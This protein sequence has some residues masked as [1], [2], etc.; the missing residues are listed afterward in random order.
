MA[1]KPD[2]RIGRLSLLGLL[3]FIIGGVFLF[4]PDLV[5]PFKP[6]PIFH[7]VVYVPKEVIGGRINEKIISLKKD[8]YSNKQ[9]KGEMEVTQAVIKKEPKKKDTLKV[10]I[11]NLQNE[12]T[13][14]E[15]DI[16]RLK[17]IKASYE[18]TS[19]ADTMSFDTLNKVLHFK[20][21]PD[22]L[23]KWDAAYCENETDT[24][25]EVEFILK[26][27]D[28][29]FSIEGKARL[30][31]RMPRSDIEFMTKYPNAGLWLLML[32]VFCSFLF[33]AASTSFYLRRQ[34][35]DLFTVKE[36]E[37]LSIWNY[38]III[39][40]T[41]LG[42]FAIWGIGRLSFND[43]DVVR[44]IFFLRNISTSLLWIQGV[45]IIAGASCLAGFIYSAGLLAYFVKKA[46]ELQDSINKKRITIE[47]NKD[48]QKKES[49]KA[50]LD[51]EI[52][53]NEAELSVL[54]SS[55]RNDKDRFEK[56]RAHFQTYFTLS[57]IILSLLV[58]CAGFLYSTINN[59]DF[60]KML[61]SDWGYSPARTDFIYMYGAFYTIIL[62]LVYIPAKM[63]FSEINFPT[64]KETAQSGTEEEK[65][66]KKWW[67]NITNPFEKFSGML[68][69]A[70][71]LIASVVQSLF[72]MLFD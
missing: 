51:E 55:L 42:I 25:R 1:T 30:V 18:Y 14:I 15:D 56:L 37:G 19:D 8:E 21:T 17:E 13:I 44:C 16:K 48:L 29:S 67:Q 43:E 3:G 28:L 35:Q 40:I 2:Y 54:E 20:F 11:D 58:L 49:Q 38:L 65:K 71:P 47:E 41:M 57:A 4:Y 69:A 66:D 62:L 50:D 52:K 70:S 31:I 6:G 5:S 53:G 72:E 7:E 27:K 12:I 68:I 60:V 61:S 34:I 59:L 36:I 23:R 46:K 22:D 33:I 32:M 9:K 64:I 26:D 63:R 10:R 39:G 24:V 45:G